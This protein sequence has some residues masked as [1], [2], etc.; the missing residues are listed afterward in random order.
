MP[1]SAPRSY[2][3]S[4]A[5][6]ERAETNQ[7]NEKGH[8]P[9]RDVDRTE[10]GAQ[11]KNWDAIVSDREALLDKEDSEDGASGSSSSH[12]LGESSASTDPK[13]SES[14]QLD[15]ASS[16][17]KPESVSWK[18]LPRKDQ[19]VILTFARFSE[20]L[21]QTSLMAYMFYQLKSFDSSLSDSTISSQAGILQA[22]FSAAQFVTAVWWG[23]VADHIGRKTVLL[24]GL[25][26]TCLSV[27][28]FGFSR[29][30]V[31]AV[32]FRVLGGALNGNVGVMRTMVSEIVKEKKY[33]FPG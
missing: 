30:F 15:G 17:S 19:L 2:E 32:F 9:I 14:F 23:R 8:G 18:S 10:S 5:G 11:E 3:G 20:P 4:G 25:W 6:G 26:G 33:V 24:I 27:L 28:A 29:T 13:T 12:G 21:A 22:S 7:E 16:R 31:Q 1:L